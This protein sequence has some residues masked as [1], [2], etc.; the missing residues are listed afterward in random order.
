MMPGLLVSC[1]SEARERVSRHRN[2][3]ARN[4]QPACCMYQSAVTI[5]T[6]SRRS[7]IVDMRTEP[8]RAVRGYGCPSFERPHVL[9]CV[10]VAGVLYG[11]PLRMRGVIATGRV[12][13]GWPRRAG[14]CSSAMRRIDYW[15]YSS[16][17]GRE[18]R[19]SGVTLSSSRRRR[20]TNGRPR[21]ARE[22][23]EMM[24]ICPPYLPRHARRVR[25]E[26]SKIKK[27]EKNIPRVRASW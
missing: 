15:G 2:R 14:R 20:A 11:A 18:R 17:A 5:G 27:E 10:A 16:A 7:A 13:C 8:L 1:I 4:G 9:L 24:P 3:H 25:D 19:S 6:H 12:T 21:S 23:E 22:R 26:D